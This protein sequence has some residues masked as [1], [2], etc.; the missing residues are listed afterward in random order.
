MRRVATGVLFLALSWLL[1]RPGIA[2][3]VI[4][5]N[6]VDMTTALA[7]GGASSPSIFIADNFQLTSGQTTITDVHWRGIYFG[8]PDSPPPPPFDQFVIRIYEDN[9]TP[10]LAPGSLLF[11][12]FATT[13]SIS[14]TDTGTL[15]DNEWA[16]YEFSY[17]LASPLTLLADTTYWL[18]IDYVGPLTDNLWFW[19]AQSTPPGPGHAM[20]TFTGGSSWSPVI[21]QSGSFELDFQLTGGASTVS[22]P[23]T[24][25]LLGIGLA[26]LAFS[27]RKRA[28]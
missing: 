24:L 9:P 18:S 6:G 26:G 15:L 11:G 3:P 20:I 28:A 12:V 16:I 27:R 22:E 1:P 10:L 14:R 7:S 13:P 19:G 23:A 25:A 2:D 17:D 8:F 5:D 4:Y 21:T